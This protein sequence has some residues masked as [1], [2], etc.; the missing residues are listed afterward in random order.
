[1]KDF[2]VFWGRLRKDGS[3]TTSEGTFYH[4]IA[5]DDVMRDMYSFFL[6][7]KRGRD[8]LIRKQVKI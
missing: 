1:M 4:V 8:Y 6:V 2:F 5:P 7:E 3:L